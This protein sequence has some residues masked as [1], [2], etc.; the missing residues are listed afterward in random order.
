MLNTYALLITGIITLIFFIYGIIDK[1]SAFV[2]F[3]AFLAPTLL[4]CIGAISVYYSKKARNIGSDKFI[5]KN[6]RIYADEEFLI[7]ETKDSL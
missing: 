2:V 6:V 7:I 3:S 4:T 1:K 5:E